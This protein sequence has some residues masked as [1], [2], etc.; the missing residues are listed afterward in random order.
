FDDYDVHTVED[1]FRYM[2]EY[3]HWVPYEDHSSTNVFLHICLFYFI[4]D[5][6]PV[7][8]FQDLIDPSTK[9]PYRWLSDWLIRY[10]QE[11]GQWMD[12]P[13]S[14]TE[15]SIDSFYAAD[16]YHMQDY[17]R[18]KWNTFNEFFARHIKKELRP[19]A[20]DTLESIVI[21]SPADCSY[22]GQW[23]IDDKANI[24]T[25]SV[26]GVPWSIS[27]LLAD[28]EHGPAFAGGIFTHSFLGPQDYHRQHAPVSGRIIEAKVIPGICYLEVT[29]GV[30]DVS[31]QDSLDAPDTA[32]Y[33]F[34]QARA[35]ILIDNPDLGLVAVLPIGMAQVS[36]VKLSVQAGQTVEKG[37]EISFFH[38]G[39]SDIIMVFQKDA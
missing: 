10:A 17:P 14:I 28:T 35:L 8:Q 2:D 26:K 39:G 7:S 15:E 16:K 27:Q 20:P 6:P 9:P 37:D 29:E 5:L 38:F 4:I 33:Q 32:G 1:Y 24:T 30:I 18:V 12:Q 31:P 11:M 13:G 34:L 19:V 22:D 36:S 3:V 21:T 25:F 23:P